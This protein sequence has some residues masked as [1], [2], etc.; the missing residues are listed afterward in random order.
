MIK[1][2]Y[3]KNTNFHSYVVNIH[4]FDP[5]PTYDLHPLFNEIMDK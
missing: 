1:Y 2:L 3:K 4:N 5:K